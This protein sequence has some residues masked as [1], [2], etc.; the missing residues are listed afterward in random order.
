MLVEDVSVFVCVLWFPGTN[1]GVAFVVGR[2]DDVFKFSSLDMI[3][4]LACTVIVT[5][6]HV[7]PRVNNSYYG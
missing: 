1:G 6:S 5:R 2:G 7:I 4:F 3:L